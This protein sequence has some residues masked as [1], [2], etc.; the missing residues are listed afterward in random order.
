MADILAT[1]RRQIL[2]LGYFDDSRASRLLPS[3]SLFK[4]LSKST[5]GRLFKDLMASIGHS[6]I[7]PRSR[8]QKYITNL[9]SVEY[10]NSG[11]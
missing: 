11:L 10:Q 3:I 6:P 4:Y 2:A 7:Y 1:L 8:Q 5:V 9:N